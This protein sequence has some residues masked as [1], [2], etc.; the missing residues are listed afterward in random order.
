[1]S[2]AVNLEPQL[3]P[4]CKDR[5]TKSNDKFSNA[6]KQ[7]IFILVHLSCFLA[8][9][10]G[11]SWVAALTCLAL[12]VLR[13]FAITAG[14]HRLFS[15][16]S[17]DT[18]RWFQF[19]MAWLGASSAQKGPLWWA[20]HHRHHHKHSDTEEDVHSPITE[21]IWWS[22]VGWVMSTQFVHSR[23]ELVKDLSRYPEIRLVDH[24]HLVPPLV[25]AIGC[26]LF[27][28]LLERTAPGLGTNGMQMLVWGFCISTVL[29][30]HGTFL[31]NSAAHLIGRQ[32]F[33]TG[34]Q[35]RNSFWVAILTLGEGWHNNHHRYPGSEKQGFYWWEVDLSHYALTVLSWFGIVWNL[36]TPP[37]RI[38]QEALERKAA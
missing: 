33:H 18:S 17:Y 23:P 12:Y 26:Y 35:S 2:L 32:R 15:H 37:E 20:G 8:L 28:V 1:M 19:V 4:K 38:Y 3:E 27:G 25:L 7:Y 11:V 9:W 22:H 31:V 29:L 5:D 16:R 30:Y 14:Y 6:F 36:R 10:T 13:M 34:D 24:Y 21:T